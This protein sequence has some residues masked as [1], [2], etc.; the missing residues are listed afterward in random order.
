MREEEYPNSDVMNFI[1]SN[2]AFLRHSLQVLLGIIM[3]N[4]NAK[5]Q[6]SEVRW[7]IDKLKFEI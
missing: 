2:V 5:L 3:K 6:V 7:K 4:T 1:E